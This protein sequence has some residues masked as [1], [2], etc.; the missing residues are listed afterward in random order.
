MTRQFVPQ[1]WRLRPGLHGGLS[2][3]RTKAGHSSKADACPMRWAR[4]HERPAS[5]HP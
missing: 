5:H 4:A 3:A 2:A 1:R